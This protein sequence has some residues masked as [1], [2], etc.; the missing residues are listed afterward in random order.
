MCASVGDDMMSG[1]VKGMDARACAEARVERKPTGF[2]RRHS[3]GLA[4]THEMF[5]AK[6]GRIITAE[7][8]TSE[9]AA[10]GLGAV[11]SRRA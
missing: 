6:V 10:T 7:L 5:S 1:V 4:L 2:Q 3:G 9:A 8:R 11:S